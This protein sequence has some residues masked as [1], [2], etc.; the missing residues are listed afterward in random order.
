[1]SSF[2]CTGAKTRWHK[3]D[4]GYESLSKMQMLFRCIMPKCRAASNPKKVKWRVGWFKS[5]V[6]A[7][8]LHL[9][10]APATS[11]R[12]QL[13]L[14]QHP[15]LVTWPEAP[16]SALLAGGGHIKENISL[17]S[18]KLPTFDLIMHQK[19]V[20]QC[21]FCTFVCTAAAFP[22]KYAI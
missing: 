20:L 21:W 22:L 7:H 12:V 3:D 8:H 15:G 2:F 4:P 6:D 14:T 17:K 13:G 5:F 9:G 11:Q 16:R 19:L 18:V 10:T 1:M